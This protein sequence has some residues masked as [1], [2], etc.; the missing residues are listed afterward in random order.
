MKHNVFYARISIKTGLANPLKISTLLSTSLSSMPRVMWPIITTCALVERVGWCFVSVPRF[1]LSQAC[2]IIDDAVEPFRAV[3]LNVPAI[4]SS[5]TKRR[6][7]VTPG[8]VG[9]PPLSSVSDASRTANA[10]PS[11]LPILPREM[12]KGSQ[13]ASICSAVSNKRLTGFSLVPFR[14]F[15]D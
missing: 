5:I 3:A 4:S 2:R 12:C 8:S 11:P 6:L 13:L 1:P 10:T 9:L 15:A 14:A 7:S